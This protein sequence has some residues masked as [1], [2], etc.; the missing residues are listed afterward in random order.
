MSTLT[1]N[2]LLA[3]RQRVATI[4]W[5]GFLSA[6]GM[7]GAV[8]Y[9]VPRMQ[10]GSPILSDS[11]LVSAFA[12]IA[13]LAGIGS[14]YVKRWL[15]SEQRL[16][17]LV[18]SPA[19]AD[20]FA[21]APNE[22]LGSISREQLDALSDQERPRYAVA[23]TYL[24]A[25]LVSCACSEVVAI[26]GLVAAILYRIPTLYFAFAAP[27]LLLLVYHRPNVRGAVEAVGY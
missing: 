27:A 13:G 17:A 5:L 20:R 2:E 7:Y 22:S 24:I 12:L 1:L 8:A 14:V 16:A 3:S 19:S 21:Q 6:L 10:P 23:V 11:A 15:L 25:F 18:R 4:L 9:A 26:L